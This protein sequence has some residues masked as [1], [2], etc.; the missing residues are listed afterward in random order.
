MYMSAS[1]IRFQSGVSPRDITQSIDTKL[2]SSFSF[3]KPGNDLLVIYVYHETANALVNAQFFISHGLHANAD[4][5]FVLNGANTLKD[6]IP[7][8]LANVQY[9]ERDNSCFDLGTYGVVLNENDG[10]NVRRYKRFVLMNASVRGPFVPA[11]ADIC[12]SDVYTGM[13]T[14]TVKVSLM[15]S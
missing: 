12:W 3:P 10:A 2:A 7:V 13:I 4:F 1:L 11:W 5:I 8:H 9:R 14:D 15:L 6:I